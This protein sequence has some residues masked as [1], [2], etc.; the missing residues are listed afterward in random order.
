[1]PKILIVDGEKDLIGSIKLYLRSAGHDLRITEDAEHTLDILR[2]RD[3]D[4][5]ITGL[6]M[7]GMDGIEL[8]KR[9]KRVNPETK[10]VMITACASV[11]TAV[12]AMKQGAYDYIVKPFNPEEIILTI[13]KVIEHQKVLEENRRLRKDWASKYQLKDIIGASAKMKSVHQLVRTVAPTSSTILIEGESGTG[14]ELV[15]HAI[16]SLSPR[17]S[18]PFVSVNCAAM[19]RELLESELFG[20]EKGAFTG[21]I[22]MKPGKF[23][24]ANEG[25]I[26]LDEVADM[27]PPLQSKVLR[28]LQERE[29]ERVGGTKQIQVDVRVIAATNRDLRN[30]KEEGRF[31][32]DLYYRIKVITIELPP[33]RERRD[34]IPLLVDHFLKRYHGD[35]K[36]VSPEAMALLMS[37]AWPGNARELENVVERAVVLCGGKI[38]T[39]EYL[40]QSMQPEPLWE[41]FCTAISSETV[42]IH[43][44]VEAFE[45]M[46]VEVKLHQNGGN[47][48][49]TARL[50]GLSRKGLHNKIKRYGINL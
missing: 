6:K 28:V 34:D 5:I 9:V 40:P 10:V 30:E 47:I 11:E 13:K 3:F 39:P 21:A 22:R 20:H 27:S 38:I 41:T 15:A 31:R 4:I 29:F 46:L 17:R 18:R 12:E 43:E 1:M 35:D 48:S 8:L 19:P 44:V 32:E 33:L 49:K 7:H 42:P 16:H 14:K 50:L 2:Q 24:V 37:H 36:T 23:E 25:T 45:K 26:Y